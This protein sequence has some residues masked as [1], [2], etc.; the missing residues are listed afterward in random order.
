MSA[1]ISTDTTPSGVLTVGA[2]TTRHR[3]NGEPKAKKSRALSQANKCGHGQ[4]TGCRRPTTRQN[5][6]WRH[7]NAITPVTA[8]SGLIAQQPHQLC[9]PSR[10]VTAH[11][12]TK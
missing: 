5:T 8:Q 10:Y 2:L 3:H 6:R 1:R 12:K 11:P 4:H 9:A 7:T